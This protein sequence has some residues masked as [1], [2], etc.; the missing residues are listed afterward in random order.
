[1]TDKSI[2]ITGCSSGIGYDAAIG[3]RER[4]WRVFASCRQA[5]DCKRLEELGFQSPRMD[6]ADP[7]SLEAG[8]E[9]VLSDTGGTL[10]AVFHNGAYALPGPVEDLPTDGMRAIFEAN[11]FGWHDLTCR[12]IPVMRAQ[13]HGR[14]I[15]N[16]S[17]LGFA[18]MRWRGA[19]NSTKFALEGWADTLRMEMA[20]TGIRIV[21]IQPGPIRTKIRENSIPHFEKWVDWENSA[22]VD[23]YRSGLLDALY[24]GQEGTPFELEPE[25]VTAKL[26]HALESLR[27][28]SHYKVTTPTYMMAA[29][30]RVLP[31]R[32]M[33]WVLSKG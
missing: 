2:L 4:G 9:T 18:P 12:I 11:F 15:L 29:L 26:V 1:M 8:L 13:G 16:S 24:K 27:P 17:V 10:D 14:I 33:D 19:Y 21:L 30:K 28:R 6:Y 20:D 5:Q 25:A 31:R 3:L 32:A 7:A 22:R 23:Q